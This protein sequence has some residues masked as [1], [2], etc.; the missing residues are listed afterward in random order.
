MR[1]DESAIVG[2]VLRKPQHRADCSDFYCHPDDEH[3]GFHAPL[4]V[5]AAL[6]DAAQRAGRTWNEQLIYVI[7]ICREAERVSPD[8]ERTPNGWRTLMAEVTICLDG[9]TWIP[10]PYPPTMS[11]DV[12]H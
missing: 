7:D 11:N 6:E 12:L 9:T 2:G 5:I 4:E 3:I 1:Y 8:D 10:F